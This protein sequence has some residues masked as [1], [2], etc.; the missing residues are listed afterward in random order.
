M[1]IGA[2][3]YIGVDDMIF[4]TVGTHEQPFD[5]LVKYMDDWAGEHDEEVIMQTGFSEYAPQNCKWQK[6]Y[7]HDWL[8]SLL[9]NA[10]IVISHGGPSSFFP[11]IELGKTVIVV[12]RQYEKGEHV[13]DHQVEFCGELVKRGGNLI[14]IEN[15]EDL[16]DAIAKYDE[17]KM[18]GQFS[19]NNERFCEVFGKIVAELI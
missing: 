1:K 2:G 5:R 14:V 17:L 16:D 3:N 4:V 13:N 7:N 10:R 15:I 12:P 18:T 19:S 9:G 6:F 8:I 11:V